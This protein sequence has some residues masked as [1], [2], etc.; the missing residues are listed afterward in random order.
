MMSVGRDASWVL[1][2]GRTL[3]YWEGGDPGGRGVVFHPGSPCTR[4]IGRQGHDAALDLGV[5]LVSVSRPGYGASG[6][7]EGAPSLATTGLDTSQLAHHLGMDEYSVLGSSGGGPF[8]VAAALADP[9]HVRSIGLVAGTGPWTVINEPVD[10]DA[11]ERSLLAMA[12]LGDADGAWAGYLALLDRELGG[13]RELDDE[14]RVDAFF[15]G[16]P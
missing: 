13:L 5:R 2:D 15:A 6:L 12:D 1:P 8:A 7:P 9:E 3:E 14:A 16:A 4:V 11:E 10:G